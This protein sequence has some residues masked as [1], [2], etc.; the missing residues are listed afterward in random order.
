MHITSFRKFLLTIYPKVIFVK[1]FCKRKTKSTKTCSGLKYLYHFMHNIE[2]TLPRK[3]H[4][5]QNAQWIEINVTQ[6]FCIRLSIPGSY[7]RN[8]ITVTEVYI[9]RLR[10]YPYSYI[11]ST[12]NSYPASDLF[13][14]IFFHKI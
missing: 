10:E 8:S 14:E 5:L 6:I 1:N 11:K 7:K 9:N 2:L 13:K 12:E 4:L 3:M